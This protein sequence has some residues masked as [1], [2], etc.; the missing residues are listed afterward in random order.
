MRAWVRA[1]MRKHAGCWFEV[2]PHAYAWRL[3]FR[4][5]DDFLGQTGAGEEDL[6]K[7]PRHCLPGE[8]GLTNCPPENIRIA[9]TP[10]AFSRECLHLLADSA[11][12]ERVSAAALEI[13]SSQFSSDAG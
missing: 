10:E 1:A 6:F 8:L 9:D 5:P 11:V 4:I 7:A 12:R 2:S 3:C 13:V